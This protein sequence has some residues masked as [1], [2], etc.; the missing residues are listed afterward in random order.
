MPVPSARTPAAIGGRFGPRRTTS[1]RVNRTRTA[2]PC[3][4]ARRR[5]TSPTSVVTFPPKAPPLPS[6]LAG[7]PP[8]AHH[9][10][11]GSR[12]AGSTHVVCS[13]RIQAP[14]GN[15]IGQRSGAVVRR[16]WILALRRRA[17]ASDSPTT[18][19]PSTSSSATSASGGAVSSANPPRPSATC[20]PTSCATPPSN[21]ARLTPRPVCS[22]LTGARL[23]Q[24]ERR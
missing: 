11:S 21:S 14:G 3:R 22:K 9:A 19:S 5:A 13:V 16:P 12:Y 4:S 8:G 7:V 20:A 23:K 24:T 10:A 17:S 18:H 15:S 1:S 6:E 2:R